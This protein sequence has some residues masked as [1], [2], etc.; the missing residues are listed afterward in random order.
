M[1]LKIINGAFFEVFL[2]FWGRGV[3][4]MSSSHHH[5]HSPHLDPPEYYNLEDTKL[6]RLLSLKFLI[7]SHDVLEHWDDATTVE[8]HVSDHP[9]NLEKVVRKP[10]RQN[11][12]L[13]WEIR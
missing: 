3:G 12:T 7:R 11:H 8:T 1:G 5:C 6:S 10:S 13:I 9:G 2:D 4:W